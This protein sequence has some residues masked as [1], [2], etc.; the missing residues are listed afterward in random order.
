MP[1][2]IGA[3]LRNAAKA[4]AR[5]IPSINALILQRDMLVKE[6]LALRQQISAPLAAVTPPISRAELLASIDRSARII[7]IGASFNP[8]APKAGGWRTMT[9]D[10]ASRA[11][12]VKKYASHP[13]IDLS[14]IEDVDFVWVSG[15]LAEVVPRPLHGTFDAFVASHVIEH[16]TDLI[17]F[18][19]TAETLLAPGGIVFLVVPDKRY[20]FDYFRPVTMTGEVLHANASHR[21]RH[22]RSAVFTHFAYAVLNGDGGAW[23]QNAVREF[24]FCHTFDEA[25]QQFLNV[26]EDPSGAYVDIHAWQFTPASFE[27]LLLELARLQKTDWKVQRITPATGCEFYAWLCRGGKSTAAALSESEFNTRRLALLK[28]ALLQTREQTD[29]LLAGDPSLASRQI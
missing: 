14:R 3:S 10:H 11:D 19:D 16:T 24:D 13:G 26:S 29:F 4:I 25:Y 18:F 15:A 12:L 5:Q 9:V 1:I 27:L 8:V 6:N 17:D 28:G 2:D 7:E 21:S 22:I 23:G 20:C